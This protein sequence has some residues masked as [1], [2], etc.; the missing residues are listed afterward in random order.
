[1]CSSNHLPP[2][3]QAMEFLNSQHTL[4]RALKLRTTLLYKLKTSTFLLFE[5]HNSARISHLQKVLLN[6]WLLCQIVKIINDE[7]KLSV[8]KG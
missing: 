7:I 4:T 8:A 5:I 6:V 2:N 3:S 1:M